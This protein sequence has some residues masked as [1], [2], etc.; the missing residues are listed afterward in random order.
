[1]HPLFKISWSTFLLLGMC[2]TEFARWQST[3]PV[4]RPSLLSVS[5]VAN[6]STH[7]WTSYSGGNS[8][9]S[10]TLFFPLCWGRAQ[11]RPHCGPSR[12]LT[13]CCGIQ[14]GFTQWG[15]RSEG[16]LGE[17]TGVFS[18][19]SWNIPLLCHDVWAVRRNSAP[20]SALLKILLDYL[21]FSKR[22]CTF[23]HFVDG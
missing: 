22:A 6:H 2:S 15:E 8:L 1:M 9:N 10:F 23:C 21:S 13:V 16:S 19:F 7:K 5:G 17:V 20:V 3:G 14:F 11:A 12:S 18:I 4:V